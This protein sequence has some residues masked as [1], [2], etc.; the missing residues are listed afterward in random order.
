MDQAHIKCGGSDL[1]GPLKSAVSKQTDLLNTQRGKRPPG[2]SMVR[3]HRRGKN[4][5]GLGT[6][7]MKNIYFQKSGFRHKHFRAKRGSEA[8]D[9]ARNQSHVQKVWLKCYL[10][11]THFGSNFVQCG[12]CEHIK[13]HSI[14]QSLTLVRSN[15][16]ARNDGQKWFPAPRVALRNSSFGRRLGL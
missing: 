11:R 14:M 3:K 10:P 6:P 13:I 5:E 4:F 12:C 2:T 8:R 1:V 9:K 16:E 15:F 7:W